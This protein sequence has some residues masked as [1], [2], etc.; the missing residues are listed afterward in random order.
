MYLFY[1]A[2]FSNLNTSLIFLTTPQLFIKTIFFLHFKFQNFPYIL[3]FEYVHVST[4]TSLGMSY[5]Q[6]FLSN[7]IKSGH[8][9]KIQTVIAN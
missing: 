7:C 6:T 2:I 4:E 9:A 8:L 3:H 5:I 1:T